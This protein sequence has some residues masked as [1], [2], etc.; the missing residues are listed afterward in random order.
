MTLP[1][2]LNKHTYV[3]NG[4]Q[5]D[6]PY[7]FPIF[8]TNGSEIQLY[9]TNIATGMATQIS[10]N[11]SIDVNNKNVTYPLSGAA[12]TSD[13][14]ITLLRVVPIT[15]EIDLP[16]GGA[17]FPKTIEGGFDK[18]TAISQQLDE[19]ISRT[20][21]I[22]IGSNATGDSIINDV[23][24]ASANAV[25][26][27][28]EA[29]ASASQ[30]A[31]SVSAVNALY[32]GTGTAKLKDLITEF[33]IR[34]LPWNGKVN[35]TNDDAAAFQSLSDYIVSTGKRATI[36]LPSGVMKINS[37]ITINVSYVSVVGDGTLIEASS[38]SSGSA[39]TLTGTIAPPYRQALNNFSKCGLVGP[40][41]ETSVTG[42]A[43]DTPVGSGA[44][45]SHTNYGKMF[46]SD[47]GT[48]LYL[49]NNC[50]AN[51]FR[52]VDIYNCAVCIDGP[53]GVANSGERHSFEGCMFF[54]SNL[55]VR[56]AN[57]N[58]SL[59][60]ANC[61]FDYNIKQFEL[62][63]ASKTFLTNCH[64]EANNYALPPIT[65]TGDGCTFVMKGGWFLITGSIPHTCSSI[66]NCN[67]SGNGGAEFDS[68]FMHN[69]LTSTGY[70]AEGTG[71]V[72]VRYFG[73]AT[74]S[75][76]KLLSANKNLLAS[77]SLESTIFPADNIFI[78]TDTAAI[79]SRVTGTN[80]QLT[81]DTSVFRTGTAS[82]KA[83]KV[84]GSGSNALFIIAVPI[85]L[86]SKPNH[87]LYYKKP[88]TE[89]GT[90]FISCGFA[91]LD[92]LSSGIP[93][94]LNNMT[95]SSQTVTFTS[96]AV[97]WTVQAS[98]DPV[99][100]VPSWATHYYISVNISNFVGPGDVYFDDIEIT[101]M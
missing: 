95:R 26:S 98:G 40:G 16:N 7:T 25:L 5:K 85:G 81:R 82:L 9:L 71:S 79:T 45:A 34:N 24:Q 58:G 74:T 14:K 6:W 35:G 101:T 15:Q 86:R 37:G 67:S 13:S 48:G 36:K 69:L 55:A 10:S 76:P 4:L 64:V 94:I 20:L 53:S 68:V 2:N 89:T 51:N 32:D 28:N 42:L 54:N 75:N 1:S 49:G 59:V 88:G 33:D 41:K 12:L 92:I 84:G 61:S 31:V 99:V 38:L 60:F 78:N 77:G 62:S 97:D 83:H 90:M 70:F 3:G 57:S 63:G 23:L 30:A 72:E 47:F 87:R 17:Y 29:A 100:T 52:S 93:K 66:V 65:L 8:S 46:I 50:Y 44:G 80:I 56:F 73:N 91:T 21:T 22:P 43:F 39:I 11:Y 96:S 18:Q 27:K 19:R